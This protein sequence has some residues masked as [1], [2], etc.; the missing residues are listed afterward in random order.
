[1]PFLYGPFNYHG[2]YT[3]ESNQRFDAQLKSRDPLSG[4]RDVEALDCLA[5]EA[6]MSFQGDFAM[7][8]NNR[9]LLWERRPLVVKDGTRSSRKQ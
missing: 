9:I 5:N 6:G 7:P 4:I 1:M 2:Q 8:A 3:S